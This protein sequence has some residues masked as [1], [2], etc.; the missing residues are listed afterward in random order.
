MPVVSKRQAGYFGLL[1][2]GA[3]KKKGISKK[4]AGEFLRG[5]KV[6]NLPNRIG[7]KTSSKKKG[8]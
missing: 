6:K 7:K 3:I 8:R 4:K 5:V 1:R 2:S